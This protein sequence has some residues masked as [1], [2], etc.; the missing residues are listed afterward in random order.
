MGAPASDKRWAVVRAFRNVLWMVVVAA[1]VTGCDRA[2]AAQPVPVQRA[3]SFRSRAVDA[4]LDKA[5]DAL[6]TRGFAPDGTQWRGFLVDRAS[7]VTD[8]SMSSGT[9]YVVI[10]EGSSAVREARPAHLRQRRGRGGPGL[11]LGAGAVLRYCPAQSGRYYL[12]A[13]ATAGSGLFG[14]RRF[15]GPTGLH[16][17][18]DDLFK[19]PP[20]PAGSPGPP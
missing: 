19:Q 16:I 18:V 14:V 5:G 7:K 1:A 9:C 4:A 8:V 20:S 11:H 13:R 2:E 17:R 12:A 15:R 6:Q 10:G 3:A